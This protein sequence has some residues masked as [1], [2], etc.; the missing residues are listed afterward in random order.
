MAAAYTTYTATSSIPFTYHFTCE[1][2]GRHSG[3]ITSAV[4]GSNQ[5]NISG[6]GRPSPDQQV[7]LNAGAQSNARAAMQAKIL[8]AEKGKYGEGVS[9]KCPH[10]GKIQSWELKS[11]WWKPLFA[12]LQGL[13]AGF[14]IMLFADFFSKDAGN[15]AVICMPIGLGIGLVIGLVG[16]IRAKTDA[17]RTTVR[18]K[19]EFIWP[20][21]DMGG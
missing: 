2:C 1:H 12:A 10:C 6:K 8:K 9:S 14:L 13:M 20:D 19:P 4:Q 3:M 18:N 17:V 11:G 21:L 16:R 15:A 5:I 7:L